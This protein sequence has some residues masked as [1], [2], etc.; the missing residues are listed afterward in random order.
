MTR[1]Q[2]VELWGWR[3]VAGVSIAIAVVRI[4]GLDGS[5]AIGAA[6]VTIVVTAAVAALGDRRKGL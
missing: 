1:R 5:A 4:F 2:W 6:G 3:V